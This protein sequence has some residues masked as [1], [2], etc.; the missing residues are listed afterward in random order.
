[1]ILF[2]LVV[3]NLVVLCSTPLEGSFKSM[4]CFQ[5]LEEL[6]LVGLFVITVG[7]ISIVAC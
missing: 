4:K 7:I 5:C 2:R 3:E 6:V 1:M